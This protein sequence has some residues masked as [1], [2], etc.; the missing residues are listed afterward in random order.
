MQQCYAYRTGE[1]SCAGRNHLVTK[2]S[3]YFLY[4][5]IGGSTCTLII[6]NYQ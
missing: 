4:F 2:C 3:S 6:F 1:M 5:K